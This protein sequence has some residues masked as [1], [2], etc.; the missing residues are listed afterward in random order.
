MNCRYCGKS[1]KKIDGNYMSKSES[2]LTLLCPNCHS[3]TP[4]YKGANKC[5]G[6]KDRKKY[7]LYDNPELGVK[8]SVETL[9][10]ESKSLG[11]D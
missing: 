11:Y 1:L 9:Y 7:S 8:P 6:R 10:D 2:N 4:T 3:L 5:N